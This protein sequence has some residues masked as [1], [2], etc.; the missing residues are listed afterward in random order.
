MWAV[1]KFDKNNLEYLKKDFKKKL[2]EDVSIYSPI[3]NM[4]N[5]NK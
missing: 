3:L 1:I 2:G 4:K 5:T